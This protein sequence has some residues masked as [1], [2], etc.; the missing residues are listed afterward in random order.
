M[1]VVN[2]Q[3][4]IALGVSLIGAATPMLPW[5][6]LG[7]LAV[8]LTRDAELAAGLSVGFLACA[9]LALAGDKKRPIR[10]SKAIAV[11]M[12]LLGIGLVAFI[13]L[14]WSLLPQQVELGTGAYV[15]WGAAA[16][17]AFVAWADFG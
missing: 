13:G 11:V 6:Q 9:V 2:T 5:R 15:A 12:T 1:H 3:R 8:P 17:V 16:F 10:S 4:I 7:L 14:I